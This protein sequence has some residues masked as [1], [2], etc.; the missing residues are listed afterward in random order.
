MSAAIRIHS[1][2]RIS[3][4]AVMSMI[5]FVVLGFLPVLAKRRVIATPL[6]VLIAAITGAALAYLGYFKP[7]F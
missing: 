2:A 7:A 1:H 5:G 4:I 3:A 6:V